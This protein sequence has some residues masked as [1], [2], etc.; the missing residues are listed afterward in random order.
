[1]TS[2]MMKELI[3]KRQERTKFLPKPRKH[4]KINIFDQKNYS[5]RI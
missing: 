3:G 5:C 2:K 1:M 4:N